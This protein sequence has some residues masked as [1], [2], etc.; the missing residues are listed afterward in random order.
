MEEYN[1][2][3]IRELVEAAFG[4]EALDRFCHDHFT[5]IYDRFTTGQTKGKRVLILVGHARRHGQEDV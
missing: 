3:A 1:H 4:D 2:G 5:T